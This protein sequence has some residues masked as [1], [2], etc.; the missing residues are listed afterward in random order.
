MCVVLAQWV[1]THTSI[2][3][4]LINSSLT[5]VC[6]RSPT[7]LLPMVTTSQTP[8]WEGAG[9]CHSRS[10]QG[11]A[12]LSSLPPWGPRGAEKGSSPGWTHLP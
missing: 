3:L 8:V 4:V 11:G 2:F 7:W 1:W 12:G 9:S 6:V 5:H 10:Q